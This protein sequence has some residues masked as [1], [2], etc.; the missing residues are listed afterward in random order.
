M[1]S[2]EGSPIAGATL[3]IWHADADGFYSGFSDLPAGLLRGKVLADEH[4]RF[5]VRT[6]APAPY[7]I[8]HDGPTGRMIEACAWHPWRPAHIHVIV[9]ADGHQQLIT[10]LYL[11]DS[12]YLNSDVADAVKESLIV[13]PKRNADG[14]EFEYAFQLAP[15]RAAVGVA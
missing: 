2:T 10:Q 4:G 15:V 6:I 9:E 1:Q 8:P 12:E 14:L 7:M 11:A 3:D 5:E 13:H